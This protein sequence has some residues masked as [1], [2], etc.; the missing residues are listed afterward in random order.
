L[1]AGAIVGE[2]AYAEVD[3]F[4]EGCHFLSEAVDGHSGGGHYFA[5]SVFS[6]GTYL[7]YYRSAVGGWGGVGHGDQS[8]VAAEGATSGAGFNG[9]GN[10]LSWFPKMAVE[11]DEPG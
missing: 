4:T 10:F 11:V 5:E 2:D 1:E 8:G 7:F 6:E 3:Q 9:F